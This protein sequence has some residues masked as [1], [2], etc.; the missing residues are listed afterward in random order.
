MVGHSNIVEGKRNF[1]AQS[2]GDSEQH[3]P[4]AHA[5]CFALPGQPE[6]NVTKGECLQP[7]QARPR[8]QA[9]RTLAEAR[10]LG[11]SMPEMLGAL[12]DG[13]T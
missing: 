8:R 13:T 4:V 3:A 11:L 7:P 6:P 1:I 10:A 5:P 12:G 2:S 9:S